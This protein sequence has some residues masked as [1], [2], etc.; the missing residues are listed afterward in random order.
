[1]SSDP[2]ITDFTESCSLTDFHDS[3]PAPSTFIG[4]PD[5][6][7]DFILG[8]AQ[9]KTMLRRSGTL[10]YIGGPQSDHRALFVDLHIDYL[11]GKEENIAKKVSQGLYTGNPEL[12]STYNLVLLRYYQ[13]HRMTER[14]DELYQNFRE[15]TRDDIR[16][17]LISLDKDQGRAMRMG[18][19]KVT[20]PQKPHQWSPDL[21]KLA[22][23][24]LY[25]KLRLREIL[26][27][28]NYSNT[29]TRWQAKLRQHQPSFVFPY[30]DQPLT[31]DVI[32]SEFNKATKSFRE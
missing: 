25:W 9:A 16:T 10:A 15:M 6:R 28:A 23:I 14:I 12:V 2:H 18:E 24:R 31:I 22:F 7:I 26:Q 19:K 4:A 20:K 8:S 17:H 3:D 30:L 5:R 21:R 13:D 1:M 27:S 29:F 32:R 11:S